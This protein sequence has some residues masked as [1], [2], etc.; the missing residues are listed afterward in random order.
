MKRLAFAA[1]VLA[2]VSP[3]TTTP[4]PVR[5]QAQTSAIEQLRVTALYTNLDQWNR[6]RRALR[7]TQGI[8]DVRIDAVSLDGAMLLLQF[9]GGRTNLEAEMARRGLRLTEES[10]GP[11]LRLAS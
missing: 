6:I 7:Q 2:A 9:R 3:L 11:V 10:Y 5:A 4:A 8:E 1:L